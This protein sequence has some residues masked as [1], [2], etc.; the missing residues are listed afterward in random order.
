MKAASRTKLA[1]ALALCASVAPIAVAVAQEALNRIVAVIEN[2]AITELE[3]VQSME[4]TVRTLDQQNREIPDR[5]TL[6][7][8]VLQQMVVRQLQLQEAKNR[9]ITIDE[10]T[11]DRTIETMARSKDLSLEAFEQSFRS[12][13]EDYQAF[14]DNAREGLIIR[15][16]IQREVIDQIKVSEKEIQEEP[17]P[18]ENG[19]TNAEHHFAQIR[20]APRSPDQATV[21]RKRLLQIRGQLRGKSFSSFGT[22]DRHFS[23]LWKSASA[24]E[25]E[26]LAYSIEDLRWRRT[27]DLPRPVSLRIDSLRSDNVSPVISSGGRLYLFQRLASRG[28]ENPAMMQQQYRVRHILM[29][30]SPIDSDDKVRRQLIQI[31]RKL[32]EG[33]DFAEFACAYSRDPLSSTQGGDLGWSNLQGFVPEFVE[34]ARRAYATGEP[35]GPF[36]TAYGWHLLE[37]TESREKNVVDET[38]RQQAIATIRQRKSEESI[39]L[40]LLGLQEKSR[41]E[42]RI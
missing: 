6:V 31:R 22:F 27:E 17:A 8:Q 41:V 3:L 35:V 30:T 19:K 33:A 10:V 11:L 37:V 34:A 5:Q 38:L 4:R 32:E 13:G 40:W 24:E 28:D 18:G 7:R 1:C 26:D 25:E 9:N 2:E 14:R 15:N 29:T 23:R 20:V 16:L 12:S 21:A 39:R 36:Q 42:I